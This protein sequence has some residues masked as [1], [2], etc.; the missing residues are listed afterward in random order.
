MM[1]GASTTIGSETRVHANH[2][3]RCLGTRQN[4]SLNRYHGPYK[5]RH[6]QSGGFGV[7]SRYTSPNLSRK[8]VAVMMG[9]SSS[10]KCLQET[11]GF[12]LSLT[13]NY[14]TL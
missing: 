6:R 1:R 14:S 11:P 4:L 2:S 10:S 5:C 13:H 8:P 7:F 12:S 3:P 9:A